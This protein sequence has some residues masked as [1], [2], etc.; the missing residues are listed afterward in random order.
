MRPTNDPKTEV[1]K[2]RVNEETAKEL[3]SRGNVSAVVRELVMEGLKNPKS[4][5]F[6]PH[7]NHGDIS[8]DNELSKY[9]LTEPIVADLRQMVKLCGGELGE[10]IKDLTVRLDEGE[11]T[12]ENGVLSSEGSCPFDYKNF[13]DACQEKG[14]NPQKM[15]DQAAQ[16][17]WGMRQ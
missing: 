13:M 11:L 12:I 1:I 4:D 14:V 17:V 9:D 5:S 15:I 7:E 8:A 6:V 16:T 3:R 2:I 10:F